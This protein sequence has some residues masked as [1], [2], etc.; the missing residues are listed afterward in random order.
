[1]NREAQ[2]TLLLLVGVMVVQVGVTDLHLRYVKPAMQAPLVLAGAVLTAAALV[3]IVRAHLRR[4]APAA[5]P[6]KGPSPDHAEPPAPVD[7]R[8]HDHGHDHGGMPRTAWLL[9]LPLLVLATVSPPPLGAYAAANGTQA[10]IEAP[11]GALPPLPPAR[12]GAVDLSLTEYVTRTLHAPETLAGV[13]LRLTGF[14]LPEEDGW[15]VARVALSCCAADGRAVRARVL[16]QEAP[17]ADT[18]VEVVG[19]SRPATGE[20]RARVVPFEASS[21]RSVEAPAQPYE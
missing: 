16:G 20:G 14:V 10:S 11:T 4:P 15:S 5:V 17:A 19:R 3:S 12:D 2:D 18:W 9:A 21:V 13:P 6:V 8:G 1:V 7:D